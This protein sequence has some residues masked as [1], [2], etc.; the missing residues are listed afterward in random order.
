MIGLAAYQ[1]PVPGPFELETFHG[2]NP[3]GGRED[4]R[5]WTVEQACT[6]NLDFDKDCFS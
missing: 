2:W 6:L 1:E 3:Q 5:L 4:D